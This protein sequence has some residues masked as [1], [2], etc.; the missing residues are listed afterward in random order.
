MNS[1]SRSIPPAAGHELEEPLPPEPCLTLPSLQVL[2]VPLTVK[3]RTGV[4]EKINVAHK[5]IPKIREARYRLHGR[6]REQR[7][8]KVADWDYIAEC[9]KIASPMPLFG[10]GDIL[11]YEDADRAMQTGVS[12][13]MIARGALIKPWIFTEIKE[14]RH[15]D[16]PSS[17]RFNILKD[18]TNYGLEHWGSDTQGV[19][20]TRKFLLEWL[21]FLCRYI[22]VGLLEHLPQKINERPPYYMGRDYLETLMASQNVDDWIKISELL[23]GPVPTNFTFLPKHKANSYK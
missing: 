23:L 5:I 20:K 9:A 11:S 1:V 18:F 16:I 19:E 12:G 8:T 2:D 15:W 4:Q 22:P 6:S 14:Q 10:N 7:Y 21:S 3:I 13:I 17:E